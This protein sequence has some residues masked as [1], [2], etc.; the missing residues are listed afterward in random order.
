MGTG[1]SEVSGTEVLR[2]L[3][4][5]ST[6]SLDENRNEVAFA[7]EAGGETCVAV[8]GDGF[9]LAMSAFMEP[10]WYLALYNTDPNLPDLQKSNV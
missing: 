8:S 1:K 5:A 4:K 10:T 6:Y 3:A 7:S 9:S 2:N